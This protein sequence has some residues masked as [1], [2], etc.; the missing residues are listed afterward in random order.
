M[1]VDVNDIQE[2]MEFAKNTISNTIDETLRIVGKS[3]L[4]PK[5]QANIFLNSLRRSFDIEQIW[6]EFTVAERKKMA[7]E[8]SLFT[9]DEILE[10]RRSG[11]FERLPEDEEKE[12][13]EKARENDE[14]RRV[15]EEIL[16]KRKQQT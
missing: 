15:I 16:A 4:S 14:K 1:T 8:W 5:D 13:E 11:A 9:S 7:F 12:K 3:Y 10:L 2:A 6:G